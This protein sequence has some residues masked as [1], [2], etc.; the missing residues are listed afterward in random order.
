MGTDFGFAVILGKELARIGAGLAGLG[1]HSNNI[2]PYIDAFG[3]EE[4]KQ[5]YLP[6][7]ESGECVTANAMTEPGAGF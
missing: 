5:C 4:H 1:T 3:T 6:R 7:C 2:A